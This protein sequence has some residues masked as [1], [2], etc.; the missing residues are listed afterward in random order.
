MS[1]ETSLIAEI[2]GPRDTLGT[3]TASDRRSDI[4]SKMSQV[5]KLLEEVDCEGLLL[6]APENFAWA[7]NGATARGILDPEQLPAI[8]T[9][10]E[11]R[12]I[13][14]SNVDTQR[15]FDEELD[16]LGFQLKEWPWHWGR[17]QMLQEL[18]VNRRLACD[19]KQADHVLVSPQMTQMRL[20]LSPYEQA[21][22]VTVG[23]LV[24]HALEAACRT[25]PA[26]LTE[27]EIAAQIAYRMVHRGVQPIQVCAAVD[28]RSRL[29]RQH[30]F[31]SM[32]MEKFVVVTATGKK[33]GMCATASRTMSFG[34]PGD[35]FRASH[36]AASKVSATYVASSW[37][38]CVPGQILEA[39]KNVYQLSGVE[40][41]WRELP[42]GFF[43]GRRPV[44]KI[45]TFET[46]ELLKENQAITW[47]SGSGGAVVTDTC[48]I[49]KEGPAVITPTE[50]WPLKKI[51]V[52]GADFV[53]PGVLIRES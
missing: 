43:T 23:G 4:D 50:T 49:T 42:Q 13:L 51:R 8:Y 3:E 9:N 19:Q 25:V 18:F 37:P 44:E 41:E 7:T 5:A 40:H 2:S 24:A 1:T 30:G 17:E 6:L 15:L 27:R 22:L 53:R 29:Y 34:D 16:G 28:G 46:G 35:A 10:G 31:T 36:N 39:G 52:Q 45:I 20:T 11:Q 38:D 47:Q 21:C 32:K 33:Y 14:C 26:G 48:L 12:W